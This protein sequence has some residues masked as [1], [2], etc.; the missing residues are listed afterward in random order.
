MFRTKIRRIRAHA[1][2]SLVTRIDE[3]RN[4]IEGR[5]LKYLAIS[6]IVIGQNAFRSEFTRFINIRVLTVPAETRNFFAIPPRYGDR[7]AGFK[8]IKPNK[9]NVCNGLCPYKC[10][11]YLVV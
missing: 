9:C 2:K 6:V 10:I 11:V 1:E 4:T 8:G 3:V 5:Y 7:R